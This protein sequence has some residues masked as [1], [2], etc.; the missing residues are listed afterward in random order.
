MCAFVTRVHTASKITLEHFSFT[1]TDASAFLH[2]QLTL[3][4]ALQ[5]YRQTRQGYQ[6]DPYTNSYLTSAV[7]EESYSTSGLYPLA[8]LDH[9]DIQ[10]TIE[11]R[12]LSVARSKG[13]STDASLA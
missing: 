10:S 4:T 2:F 13:L 12:S 11:V 8:H 9:T 3:L 1:L 6:F 5:S 7:L